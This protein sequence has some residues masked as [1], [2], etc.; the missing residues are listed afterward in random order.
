MITT[1]FIFDS[2]ELL[3]GIERNRGRKKLNIAPQRANENS[4]TSC[5]KPGEN[6]RTDAPSSKKQRT[7]TRKTRA[8]ETDE[9]DDVNEEAMKM[10]PAYLASTIDTMNKFVGIRK[11]ERL[12]GKSDEDILKSSVSH[13]MKMTVLMVEHADRMVYLNK[14]SRKTMEELDVARE[15][16][17]DLL[18]EKAKMREE[19][20]AAQIE[21]DAHCRESVNACQRASRARQASIR[22]KAELQM[23]KG[24]GAAKGEKRKV[25]SA[26]KEA[27]T[28]K[29]I[30]S[31]KQTEEF[32]ILKDELYME[33]AHALLDKI[34]EER[35]QWDLSFVEEND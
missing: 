26:V 23:L 35:P 3:E 21:I 29:E 14:A 33:G 20:D 7:E 31:F 24:F 16:I 13:L 2:Q 32:E 6:S 1:C 8:F 11:A 27:E 18:R 5:L 30:N 25:Y 15:E 12:R 34:K 22:L 9:E 28:S 10:L 19:L 17:A 4:S